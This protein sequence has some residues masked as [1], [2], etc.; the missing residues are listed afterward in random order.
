M[1]TLTVNDETNFLVRRG[2]VVRGC[3]NRPNDPRKYAISM[4]NIDINVGNDVTI[5][6]PDNS[7]IDMTNCLKYI[8]SLRQTIADL[9]KRICILEHNP[10][11][12]GGPKFEADF[13]E[14]IDSGLSRPN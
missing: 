1:D 12:L 10:R 7:L 11:G 13:K 2:D 4:E 9:E 8:T 14:E 3:G 6:L 5:K